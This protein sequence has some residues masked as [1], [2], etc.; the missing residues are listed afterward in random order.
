MNLQF[1][2]LLIHKIKSKMQRE[3]FATEF[4]DQVTQ[5][6]ELIAAIP[7]E[8]RVFGAEKLSQNLKILLKSC[9]KKTLVRKRVA[10]YERPYKISP[11]LTVFMNLDQSIASIHF[12][13]LYIGMYRGLSGKLGI[14][15]PSRL[16]ALFKD[17]PE[18]MDLFPN[19]AFGDLLQKYGLVTKEQHREEWDLRR[20]E[21]I[22]ELLQEC[23]T[24]F[25]GD[26]DDL[27][28]LVKKWND[29]KL[30]PFDVIELEK[31]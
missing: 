25:R 10:P 20:I 6:K 26:R 17:H 31:P 23:R 14:Q 28:V 18:M 21:M 15:Q 13:T 4:S 3:E 2:G 24:L 9:P 5:L 30:T 1:Y 8:Q 11:E 19:I 12:C 29:L 27:D 16:V 22:E 7:P